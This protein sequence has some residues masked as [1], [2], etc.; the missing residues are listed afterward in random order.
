MT[1][2][3]PRLVQVA[4]TIDGATKT[5]G[6][7]VAGTGCPTQPEIKST[8]NKFANPIQNEA[9]V[10]I[11]NLSAADQDYLLTKCSPFN[12]DNTP[13]TL[14]LSA[15]RVST[16]VSRIFMGNIVRCDPS[17][18]PDIILKFKCQTGAFNKTD[19]VSRSQ[20]G[21]ASLSTVAE[22][23]AADNGLQLAFQATDRNLTNYAFTGGALKQID[24]LADAGQ[25]DAYADDDTLVVKDAGVPLTGVLRVLNADSG[26][27][28]IP[29]ITE[30]GIKVTYLLDNTSKLGGGLQIQ[31]VIY[32]SLNALYSIFKLGWDITSR[33]KAFYWIAEAKRLS[34]S[35]TTIRPN[36]VAKKHKVKA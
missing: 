23:V 6:G 19:I 27:V 24:A 11:A 13:K 18:P 5:Y 3:D 9:E 35:G 7:P 20:A 22:G 26:M 17:Q 14:T 28:G 1:D 33:D 2:I 34:T 16:G 32:P 36:P 8:G 25:V 12:K 29:Q 10:S 15:G 30:Q 21:T 4:I 31:S